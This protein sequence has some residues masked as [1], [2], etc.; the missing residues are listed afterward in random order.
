VIS[1]RCDDSDLDPVLGVPSCE[2]VKHVDIVSGVQVVDS[3]LSVDFE[4]V[5]TSRKET[6]RSVRF[7]RRVE[8]DVQ[9]TQ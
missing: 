9:L 5:L 7:Q 3:S 2:S 8:N 1:P 4:S 6:D